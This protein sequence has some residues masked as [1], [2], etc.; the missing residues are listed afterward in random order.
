MISKQKLNNN[1]LVNPLLLCK[2]NK[3]K[4]KDVQKNKNKKKDVQ[5]NKIIKN[6][7]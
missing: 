1:L 3:N 7:H 5:K 2:K 4:K 6:Y